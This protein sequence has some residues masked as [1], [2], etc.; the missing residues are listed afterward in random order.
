MF[1]SP[2]A[3]D[4][5]PPSQLVNLTAASRDEGRAGVYHFDVTRQLIASPLEVGETA[6]VLRS[7]LF[8]TFYPGHGWADGEFVV[9]DFF[10]KFVGRGRSFED[11]FLDW[12]NQIHRQFQDLYYKRPFEMTAQE[13]TTW[14]L[15]E[16]QIN[17]HTYRVTMP[18]T[19]RQMGR[20]APRMRPHPEIIEWEDGHKEKVT[21]DQ[22]PGEFAAYVAGQPFEAIVNRDPVDFRLLKVTHVRRIRSLRKMTS[23]EFTDLIHSIPTTESLPDASWD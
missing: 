17:V 12:R 7:R 18:L 11:A 16:S 3:H 2:P 19:V 4:A 20:V 14:Q 10:P 15:L 6:Y 21:L 13:K 5:L 9:P 8:G 23:D 1:Y 22:M